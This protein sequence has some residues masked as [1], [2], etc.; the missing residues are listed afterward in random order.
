MPWKNL[1]NPGITRPRPQIAIDSSPS[2]RTQPQIGRAAAFPSALILTVDGSNRQ[3]QVPSMAHPSPASGPLGPGSPIHPSLTVCLPGLAASAACF[4]SFENPHKAASHSHKNVEKPWN[5]QEVQAK[6]LEQLKEQ[7]K[8]KRFVVNGLDK[9][10]DVTGEHAF[11]PPDFDNG[12]QRGP[13]PG[14]NALANHG[15]IPR[16]GVAS[17]SEIVKGIN[18]VY[19][20]GVDLGFILATLG[21]VWV[22]NPLSINAGFSIGGRDTGSN[23]IL[24]NGL[25]LLGEPRGLAGSHNII[26]SDGSNTR[27]DLY[28]TGDASTMNMTLF[29]EW[30]AM[31]DESE[32]GS[33]SFDMM[34]KRAAIRL[35]QAKATNPDFY[36]GPV[37]GMLI[38]SAAYVFPA[39]LFRNHSSEQPDGVLTKEIVRNFYGVYGSDDT[40]LT[41]REGWE[42]IPENWYKTPTDWGVLNLNADVLNWALK[43]PSLASIGGNTGTVNSFAGIDL[44]NLTDGIFNLTTLLEGN[45]LICFVFE[46]LKFLSPNMLGSIFETLTEPLNMITDALNVPLLDLDCP[47]LDD[48]TV[49]GKPAWEALQDLFPG[50][51]KS[52]SIL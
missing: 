20:M 8:D 51:A 40:N 39:R 45:N 49:D 12:D 9:P 32:D 19:G 17:L 41:Y 26:E 50:A 21:T 11:Q 27:N 24:N 36:Y 15:Y 3:L 35:E 52:G 48:V 18:E 38:R 16:S 34:G 37:T 30:Y 23:N 7:Q 33:L 29:E 1:E 2:R 28:V 46:I 44:S 42:R 31:F 5:L 6:A 22:G 47:A 13:C 25:G 10:I 4:P 14:L 43:Y